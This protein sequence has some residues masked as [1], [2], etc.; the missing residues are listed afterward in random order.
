M[1]Y[2]VSVAILLLVLALLGI[3]GLSVRAGFR[4][5]AAERVRDQARI[6]VIEGQLATLRAALRIGMAEQAAR[7]HMFAMGGDV[8]DNRT[9]HE[10]W[11]SS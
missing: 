11:R 7:R 5:E 10:E 8:F 3:A 9:D 6:R 1:G 4:F 2:V